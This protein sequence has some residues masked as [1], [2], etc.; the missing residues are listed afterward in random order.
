MLLAKIFLIWAGQQHEWTPC[1]SQCEAAQ[2]M[3]RLARS[4][5][6]AVTKHVFCL[7]AL[8]WHAGRLL[9]IFLPGTS[10]NAAAQEA[11]EASSAGL[12]PQ[13]APQA[14]NTSGPG[15]DEQLPQQPQQ[16]H[17][18][19]VTSHI[20][21]PQHAQHD[22]NL[23]PALSGAASTQLL[24]TAADSEEGVER[25][26]AADQYSRDLPDD[27]EWAREQKVEREALAAGQQLATDNRRA[28]QE[29]RQAMQEG[30]KSLHLTVLHAYLC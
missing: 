14:Y 3:V 28:L 30:T 22:P 25:N 27:V 23:D 21:E 20:D 26:S 17:E 24:T 2:P 9:G 4:S 13:Q 18:A 10:G 16:T 12:P 1:W 29:V 11:S 8:Y 6:A 15:A 5:C 7:M 19:P